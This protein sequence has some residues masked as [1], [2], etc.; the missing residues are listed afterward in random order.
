M[1]C[2]LPF[3][4]LFIFLL[5]CLFLTAGGRIAP[6]DEETT[7]RIT[8]NLIEYGRWTITEQT[9][10]VEPQL[11]PGFLPTTQPREL[12]T[13]WAVPGQD[14]QLYPQ[15]TPAHSIIN[16]PLYLVGRLLGGRPSLDAVLVTRFTTALFNP[17]V[18]ALTGWITALFAKRLGFSS[19]LSVALGLIY[20]V[21]SMAF[22]YAST[23]FSEPLIAC[24]IVLAA[25]A[26][27][28]ARD[29]RHPNG[30]L[31]VAGTAIGIA[32]FTRE[33]SLV[34]A[35]AFLLYGLSV[36]RLRWRAWLA[37]GLPLVVFSLLIGWLNWSR[38]GSPLSFGFSALQHT[39][40]STPPLLGLYGLLLSPGKGLLFYN[41]AAW[42][43][44]IGL[45]VMW[46]RRRAEAALFTLIIIIELVFFATYEFWTGGWNWGPRYILP[47][48]PLLILATGEW[49][50]DHPTGPR[51]VIFVVACVLGLVLNLPAALVDQS[52]YLVAF[53]ERDPDHYLDRSILRL[54]DSPLV[55]QWPTAIG[56]AQLY[57]Q[58]ET[59]TAAKQ[60]IGQHLARYTGG[61]EIEAL[62]THL[63]WVD[64]FFRLN[65]PDLW[66]MHGLLLGFSP[67]AIGASVL[68]LLAVALASGVRLFSL[69]KADA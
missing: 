46:R 58:P 66:W 41:P 29:A 30:W 42:L 50:H 49:L 18:I 27:Y 52:R 16:T 3:F 47:I 60:A 5:A 57:L 1:T 34:L 31:A 35:P 22:A 2:R 19:G 4:W 40:F 8:A 32:V 69:L 13:T 59:W 24:A 36:I 68:V 17:I 45:V 23:Y 63:M 12:L 53:G 38:Y 37:F 55:Q 6:Q 15:F 51:R 9:F 48:V 33:R 54:D 7:Y 43:G 61:G 25:Y 10:T 26:M 39:T 62:S 65:V 14:G 28:R 64:E 11:Y 56:L 67:L 20:A 44:L 21:G